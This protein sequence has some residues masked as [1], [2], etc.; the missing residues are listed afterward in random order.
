[1]QTPNQQAT[2]GQ[3]TAV[4]MVSEQ[5]GHEGNGKRRGEEVALDKEVVHDKE[6][7]NAR[8]KPTEG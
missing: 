8:Y 4:H 6:E 2:S 1:M 3:T 7:K 5:V